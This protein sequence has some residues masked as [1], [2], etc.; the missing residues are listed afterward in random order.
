MKIPFVDLPYQYSLIK[1][2]VDS[3][4][5][6]V[7]N[8]TMFILGPEVAEFE[9][10][11]AEFLGVKHCISV[12][13]GTD[14]LLIAMMAMGIK[15]GDEVIT[16]PFS[17]FATVETI[18]LLGAKPVFVDIDPRTYN[19]DVNK[20][21]A[22]ITPKTK[23]ILPV[24]LYGQC[25]DFA[26]INK[27]AAKYNLPVVEDAAQSLG[28]TCHGKPSGN[29]STIS[30]TS[31]FPTKP[32]ACY[33]DGGACFTN[34]D[35]LAKIM[36]EIRVHGQASRYYHTRIGVTGRLDTIQAAILLAKLELFPNEIKL[37]EKIGE[38]YSKLLK[39]KVIT[40]Y[41]ESFNTS[42]YG[43]YTIQVENRDKLADFLKEKGIPTAVHYPASL[44]RQPVFAG[45]YD[46][47]S[48]PNVDEVAKKV[49]SLPMHPYLTEDQ[50]KFISEQIIEFK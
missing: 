36:S 25:P 34:D 8:E 37:R 17:F 20:I 4:I 43:V 49:I 6:K 22:A 14:A 29:L 41:I 44:H 28:A 23:L 38:L 21:E 31:F 24:S 13:S 15:P 50:I 9:K 39:G 3:R 40:P 45:Q 12:A 16:S 2:S 30:C 10:K 32:L 46:H 35:N 48:L 27:I 1:S 7:L 11:L 47:V 42:V 19:I 33:G 26:A 18:I 5:Q